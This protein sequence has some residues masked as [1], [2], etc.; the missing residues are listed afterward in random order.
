[1]YDIVTGVATLRPKS[2]INVFLIQD[3]VDLEGDQHS[4]KKVRAPHH[5]SPVLCCVFNPPPPLFHL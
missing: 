2:I 1:M 4:S 3:G 5:P